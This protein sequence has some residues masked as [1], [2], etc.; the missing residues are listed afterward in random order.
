MT[1]TDDCRR[2][3]SR[4]RR[5]AVAGLAGLACLVAPSTAAAAPPAKLQ[6]ALDRV[7]AAGAPGALVLVRDGDRTRRLTSGLGNLATRAPIRV[8]DRA[9]IGGITKAF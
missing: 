7:V 2:S 6:R 8:A 3:T 4:A 1:S 9:R 5:T